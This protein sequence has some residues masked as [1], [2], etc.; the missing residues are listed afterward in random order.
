MQTVYG[1]SCQIHLITWSKFE[2]AEA[3]FSRNLDALGIRIPRDQ[4]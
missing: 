2:K 1:D 3:R 4:E